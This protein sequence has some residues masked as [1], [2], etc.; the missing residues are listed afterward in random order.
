M[1]R[2]TRS[3]D[4][5]SRRCVGGVNTICRLTAVGLLPVNSN[6]FLQNSSDAVPDTTAPCQTC[7]ALTR[8]WR[9]WRSV[10][11][12]NSEDMGTISP[13]L[14][15]I[16]LE[17]WKRTVSQTHRHPDSVLTPQFGSEHTRNAQEIL[18]FPTC[19][20]RFTAANSDPS[21]HR[22]DLNFRNVTFW[23]AYVFFFC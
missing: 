3:Q 19:P 13:F 10:S 22:W 2:H 16:A 18:S 17:W 7:M 11:G 21:T 23:C 20:A 6:E 4:V 5:R 12:V 9:R 1:C 15:I 8:Y 14:M